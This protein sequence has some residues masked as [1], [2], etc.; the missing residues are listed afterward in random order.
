MV[1]DLTDISRFDIKNVNLGATVSLCIEGDLVEARIISWIIPAS[2][3]EDQQS[4]A[5]RYRS[6]MSPIHGRRRL[7]HGMYSKVSRAITPRLSSDR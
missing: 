2:G 4:D 3:Q 7:F 5:E 1:R 6:L